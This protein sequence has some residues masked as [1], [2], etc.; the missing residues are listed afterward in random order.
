M[1]KKKGGGFFYVSSSKMFKFFSV[2]FNYDV[3]QMFKIKVSPV[4]IFYFLRYC[5]KKVPKKQYKT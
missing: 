5:E 4:R 1:T 3:P 2:Y